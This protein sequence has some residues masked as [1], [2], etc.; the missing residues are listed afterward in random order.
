MTQWHKIYEIFLKKIEKD[1]DF[2]MYNNVSPEEAMELAITR[3]NGYLIESIQYLLLNCTPDVD[4]TNY[5]KDAEVFNFD[6]TDTEM[7]L[8]A[9]IMRMKYFEKDEVLLKALIVRFSPK[10]VTVFSP[11]NERRTFMDMIKEIKTNVKVAINQYNNKDRLT[12]KL[13]MIDYAKYNEV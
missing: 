9:E 11:S 6:L 10:D 13:K 7:D 3:A 12:G 4:F 2:F 5:N 8:L 1:K